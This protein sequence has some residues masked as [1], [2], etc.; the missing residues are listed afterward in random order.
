[1]EGV[2]GTPYKIRNRSNKAYALDTN[3]IPLLEGVYET[4]KEIKLTYN[5]VEVGGETEEGE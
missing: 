1:M 2:Q 3:D 5:V 4:E